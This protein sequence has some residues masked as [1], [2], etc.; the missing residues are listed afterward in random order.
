[1]ENIEMRDLLAIFGKAS[2]NSLSEKQLGI[3]QKL[4]D[5]AR[6]LAT[7]Y[8]AIQGVKKESGLI[9]KTFPDHLY[10][11][12]LP[13]SGIYAFHPVHWRTRLFPH[14]GVP[15]L[16][17]DRVDIEFLGEIIAQPD[18]YTAVY[19]DD[20]IEDAP[21]YFLKGKQHIRK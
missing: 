11:T 4:T 16:G 3:L 2:I 20:D 7:R 12:I 21:F 5:E 18:I 6:R 8:L 17:S 15:V 1:M 10:V 14:H 9:Q 19:C 13:R